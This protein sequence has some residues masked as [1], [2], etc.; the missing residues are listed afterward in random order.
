MIRASWSV[1][2][3][4]GRPLSAA[5]IDRY[6]LA[7]TRDGIAVA[8]AAPAPSATE[9]SFPAE[10]PGVYVVTLVCVPKKGGA[11][12]PAGGSVEIFDTTDAVILDFTVEV[13]AP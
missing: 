8:V 4:S 12:D 13:I 11:S 9:L 3:E 7:V 6:E 2:R 10:T 5:D 1:K